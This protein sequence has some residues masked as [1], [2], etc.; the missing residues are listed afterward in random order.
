MKQL[1]RKNV[2]R[3]GEAETAY[4]GLVTVYAIA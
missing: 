1:E 3:G 2:E 4:E